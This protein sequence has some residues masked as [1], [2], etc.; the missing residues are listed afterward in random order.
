MLER[1]R[2]AGE[3]RAGR[4]RGAADRLPRA[5]HPGV[6]PAAARVSRPGPRVAGEL[7]RRLELPAL[8]QPGGDRG[9]PA[10]RGGPS[11]R[12]GPGSRG[13]VLHGGGG[14]RH[15]SLPGRARDAGRAPPPPTATRTGRSDGSSSTRDGS[16]RRPSRCT[17]SASWLAEN[18]AERAPRPPAQPVGRVLPPAR[19]DRLSAVSACRSRPPAPSP[20]T[21][22]C[23]RRAALAFVR[24]ERPRRLPDGRVGVEAREPLRPQPGHRWRD[25]RAGTR[26]RFWGRGSD[27]E[28]AASEMKQLGDLYFLVPKPPPRGRGQRLLGPDR[29]P[30]RSRYNRGT[31]SPGLASDVTIPDDEPN[32]W[33]RPSRR[34]WRRPSGSVFPS[35]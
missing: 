33:T 1:V 32:S 25:P 9:R 31:V 23:S 34:P 19:R 11:A 27:A 28:L 2:R 35:S 8:S 20:R 16:P 6:G 30:G 21:R 13:R 14:E 22:G 4:R 3:R 24:T 5:H 18:P 7:H 12:V 17:R 26:R 10:R 15:A 29:P